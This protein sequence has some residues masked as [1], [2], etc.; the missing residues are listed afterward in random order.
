VKPNDPKYWGLATSAVLTQD[1]G[2]RHDLLGGMLCTPENVREQRWFLYHWWGVAS[3][4]DFNEKLLWLMGEGHREEFSGLAKWLAG[5]SKEERSNVMTNLT[6]RGKSVHRIQFVLANS[7]KLGERGI[8]GWDLTRLVSLCRWGYVAGYVTEEQAWQH[9]MG[10]A[11]RLQNKFESWE[12]LGTNYLLGREFW[13]EK[14]TQKSGEGM[15]K[16]YEKLTT[17]ADSPWKL[18]PWQLDL[19]KPPEPKRD[20]D[21]RRSPRPRREPRQK[22]P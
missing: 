9:I 2:H 10:A 17:D 15:R 1:N 3:Q 13:S 22:T 8:L 4:K 11:H 20:T 7:E 12:D 18:C 21:L 6:E 14:E 16:A 5:L 19:N